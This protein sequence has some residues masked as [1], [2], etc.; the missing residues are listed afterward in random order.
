MQRWCEELYWCTNKEWY[1]SDPKTLTM[2]LTDKAPPRA[3]ESYK[4]WRKLNPSGN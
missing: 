3:V 1:Y 4:K 2:K